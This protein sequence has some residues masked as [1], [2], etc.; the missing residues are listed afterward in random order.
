MISA[1]YACD[2]NGLI[3]FKR[4]AQYF[5]SIISKK[6]RKYFSEITKNSPVVMGANTAR[7]MLQEEKS[8]LKDRINV[9]LSHDTFILDEINEVCPNRDD[10]DVMIVNNAHTLGLLLREFKNS[11]I[12][13]GAEMFEL[14]KDVI[15]RW[16][17][18]EFNTEYQLEP[19]DEGIYVPVIGNCETGEVKDGFVR[20]DCKKFEDI[21]E[22]TG[23]LITGYFGVYDA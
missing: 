8:L 7:S 4:D 20:V 11:F 19:G 5:Q 1:I 3:G 10:F 22:T 9:I 2:R 12:I 17:I 23:L 14:F 15:D 13:G 18:T 6:D 21:D 16:Y